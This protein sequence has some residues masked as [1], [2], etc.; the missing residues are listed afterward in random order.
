MHVAQKIVIILSNSKGTRSRKTHIYIHIYMHISLGY[1]HSTKVART[2]HASVKPAL[3]G[4]QN[5]D[6]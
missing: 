5:H 3:H 4:K 1:L 2:L 6:Y